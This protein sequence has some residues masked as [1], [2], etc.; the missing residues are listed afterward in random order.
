MKMS[1]KDEKP[2]RLNELT[3]QRCTECTNFEY[4]MGKR[5]KRFSIY[6]NPIEFQNSRKNKYLPVVI[7]SATDTLVGHF[8]TLE[9]FNGIK[10][11]KCSNCGIRLN[12]REQIEM[13]TRAVDYVVGQR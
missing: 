2:K 4:W 11:I 13:I 8:P 6:F 12:Q 1:G 9:E 3:F 7:Y 5:T 10:Y